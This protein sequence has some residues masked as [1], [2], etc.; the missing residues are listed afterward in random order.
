MDNWEKVERVYSCVHL[1]IVRCHK[2]GSNIE[3]RTSLQA[4]MEYR[5]GMEVISSDLLERVLALRDSYRPGEF[6][7]ADVERA[8]ARER[9]SVMDF[10]ALLSVAAAPF[11]EQMAVRA[12]RERGRFFG[13]GVGLYT[14]LYIANYCEN[15]CTYCGFSC[16]NR[17]RRGKLSPEEM[18]REMCSIA[19]T[20]LREIL[21]LT[22]ESRKVS[23]PAYIGDA[24]RLARRF[25]TTIG[26]ET[27]PV[28]VDEYRWF[29]EC[30]AD[31][32]SVYQETYD[33]G[34]YERVHPEGAKRCF[35]YRFYAQERALLGGMRG[36]AF[37]VLLGL[38]EWR[39]DAFAAGAHAFLVQRKFPRGEIS[40]SFPRLRP[41]KQGTRD[42]RQ[43]ATD[44]GEDCFGNEGAGSFAGGVGER[45]LLQA[46]LAFRVFMPFAGIAISTRERAGFRDRVVGLAATKMSAG[47]KVGVGGHGI[48]AK[49]DEQ[50]AISDPRSVEEIRA[51][52]GEGG[53]QCVF[54]DYI[55]V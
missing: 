36:V 23:G 51:M 53:L 27:Y 7:G 42:N 32:V 31:F 55:R 1:P 20:G 11:L 3:R 50:F 26:L 35:P 33:V 5:E 54:R 2:G 29:Q 41:F 38:G 28:N 34:C 12:Q 19:G 6:T 8:L 44:N 40:F 48:G 43:L 15:G 37:G 22:G 46:I 49:G 52:I 45:E 4:S 25:F 39:E 30:G 21:I 24:V 14:P 47:V 13:N 10:G 9:L 18:E 16:R 17:I